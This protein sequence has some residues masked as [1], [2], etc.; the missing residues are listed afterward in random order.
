MTYCEKCKDQTKTAVF[1]ESTKLYGLDEKGDG[2]LYNASKWMN[3]CNECGIV[4]STFITN[5]AYFTDNGKNI[6]PK[7]RY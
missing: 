7:E 3:V 2:K 1:Q 5:C 6:V 4:K